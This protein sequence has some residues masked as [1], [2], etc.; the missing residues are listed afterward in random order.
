[1][2]LNLNSEIRKYI[3]IITAITSPVMV[4]LNSQGAVNDFWYGLYAVVVS[5]VAALAAYNVSNK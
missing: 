1:M 3:Y 5:A 2:E 4:Y